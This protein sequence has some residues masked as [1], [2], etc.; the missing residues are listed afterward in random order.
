MNLPAL[1]LCEVKRKIIFAFLRMN[2]PAKNVNFKFFPHWN[3][4]IT[5][6]KIF[7]T[8][9]KW[10]QT[11][12]KKILNLQTQ[13]ESQLVN[14]KLLHLFTHQYHSSAWNNRQS[15]VTVRHDLMFSAGHNDSFSNFN[16]TSYTEDRHELRVT[17]TRC[18]LTDTKSAI[19]EIFISGAAQR[20]TLQH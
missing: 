6:V 2:I 10:L 11:I 14:L 9:L 16:S 3:K 5:W 15:S 1:V 17:D 13:G 20:I 12:L 8:A 4:K 7:I 19:G 18:R